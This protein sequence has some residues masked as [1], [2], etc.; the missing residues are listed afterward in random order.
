MTLEIRRVRTVRSAVAILETAMCTHRARKQFLKMRRAV[1]CIQ[2]TMRVKFVRARYMRSREA[3]TRI[4]SHVRAILATR[5]FVQLRE[6]AIRVQG[7]VRAAFARHLY[8]QRRCAIIAMQ[9]AARSLLIRKRYALVNANA[10]TVQGMIRGYLARKKYAMTQ[11]SIVSIQSFARTFLARKQFKIQIH[12]AIALQRLVRGYV[13]RLHLHNL[14][15]NAIRIQTVFRTHQ[16]LSKMRLVKQSVVLLQ[17]VLRSMLTRNMF[18]K[19]V[20]ASIVLQRFVRGFQSRS[21]FSIARRNAVVMQTAVRTYLC[22]RRFGDL[23]KSITTIQ[24]LARMMS[25]RNI[26]LSKRKHIINIQRCVRDFLRRRLLAHISAENRARLREI[27]ITIAKRSLK[28]FYTIVSVKILARRQK[29]AVLRLQAFTRGSITR[30]HTSKKLSHHRRRIRQAAKRATDSLKLGNR[31]TA[32]LSDLM[33]CKQISQVKKS[34]ESLEV[35]TRL[36]REC[37]IR[38]AHHQHNEK[39]SAVIVI[40]NM[41]TTLNRSGPHMVL[42]ATSLQV[43]KNVAQWPSL[44]RAS[45]GHEKWEEILIDSMYATKAMQTKAMYQ[46]FVRAFTLMKQITS[47]SK[48][49]EKIVASNRSHLAK[50]Q[51]I[52]RGIKRS[53]FNKTEKL[54]HGFE[55][56]LKRLKSL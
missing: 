31:T 24:S 51:S 54:K 2:S 35:A 23:K 28:K 49:E 32:A 43:L 47:S 8:S 39:Q 30:L 50:L 52:L 4:Q 15:Q 56:Y 42:R 45:Y 6:G 18:R 26:F 36:S 41:L 34:I 19:Q 20:Q 37:C 5:R 21:R 9:R 22:V 17:S 53:R 25:Y 7:F 16:Q 3:S 11:N 10:V 46:G 44:L 1:V 14:H 48:I 38:F 55:A 27:R 12:A 13:T 33:T 40:Y 29:R